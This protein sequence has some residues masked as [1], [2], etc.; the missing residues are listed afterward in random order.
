MVIKPDQSGVAKMQHPTLQ[1][2]YV[3]WPASIYI[4][5][6]WKCTSNLSSFRNVELQHPAGYKTHSP[7]LSKGFMNSF[8]TNPTGNRGSR[9]WEGAGHSA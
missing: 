4:P 5:S 3:T 9:G 1:L 6:L 8:R 2:M 7:E